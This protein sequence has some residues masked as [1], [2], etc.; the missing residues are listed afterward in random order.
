MYIH[1][2][3]AYVTYEILFLQWC[4]FNKIYRFIELGETVIVY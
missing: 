1:T 3:Y 2:T 4:D